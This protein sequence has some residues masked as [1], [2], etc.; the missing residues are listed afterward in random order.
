MTKIVLTVLLVIAACTVSVWFV[1]LAII[2]WSREI[3][4]ASA[5]YWFTQRMK[6]YNRS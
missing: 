6:R 5:L 1:P 4:V 2:L 3:I